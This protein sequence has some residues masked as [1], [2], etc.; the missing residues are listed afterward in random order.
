MARILLDTNVVSELMRT[1][2]D[3]GV[4]NWFAQR[5]DDLFYVS[6]I[7]QAEILLGIALL[8]AGK[9]RTGLAAAAA[10]MFAKDF[11]ERCLPFDTCC[12]GNY[13]DIVSN[14]RRAGFTAST[15]DAMIAAI[16]L[17][18]GCALA[19]R[20]TKDFIYI[21]RLTLMNPWMT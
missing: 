13:A 6:S 2:P 5:T 7:T 20:N 9:R 17:T 21:D 3:S 8:P 10:E 18:H 4:M 12:T 11:T 1:Q 14:R 15:E 16:A 19:T